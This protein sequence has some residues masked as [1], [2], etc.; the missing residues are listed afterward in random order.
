M[1]EAGWLVCDDPQVMLEFLEGKPSDRKSRLFACACCRRIWSLFTDPRSRR[2][3]EVAER[4]ADGEGVSVAELKVAE[5]AAEDAHIEAPHL[6]AAA[7][8]PF[9]AAIHV[10]HL[11]LSASSADAASRAADAV[12]SQAGE[13]GEAARREEC[14]MQALLVR[15]VFGNPFRTVVIAPTITR[16]NDGTVLKLAQ[17]IYD[18]RAFDRLPILADALEDAGCV[19]G[20]LL[21]HCRHQGPHARGCWVVDLLIGRN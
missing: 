18:D 20:D 8:G 15:C 2:A 14:K 13:V 3:V 21:G 17:G 9:D 1:T 5:R 11:D 4:F 7:L 6:T 19:D 12:E 16:W 10:L